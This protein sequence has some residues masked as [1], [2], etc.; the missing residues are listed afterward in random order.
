[1]KNKLQKKGKYVLSR[2]KPHQGVRGRR[3]KIEPEESN[4][5]LVSDHTNLVQKGK[6]IGSGPEARA[7]VGDTIIFNAW[8]CDKVTIENE[9]FYYILDTDEFVLEII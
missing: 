7:R 2:I 6:V 3:I 4:T 1:M 9:T 5:M 8:G